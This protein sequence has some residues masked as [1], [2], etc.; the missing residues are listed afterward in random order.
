MCL[1]KKDE[2][3][4]LYPYLMTLLRMYCSK[5]ML[6][7]LA[8]VKRNW[9]QPIILWSTHVMSWSEERVIAICRMPIC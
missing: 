6:Q 3:N 9:S 8:V 4:V 1:I 5:K 2:Y 7:T